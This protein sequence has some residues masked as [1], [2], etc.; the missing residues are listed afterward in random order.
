MAIEASMTEE[1]LRGV[2]WWG[3]FAVRV[4]FVTRLTGFKVWKLLLLFLPRFALRR[5]G[6]STAIY[7][8]NRTV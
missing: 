6:P 4:F 3:E 5:A 2:V 1:L 8:G 7:K